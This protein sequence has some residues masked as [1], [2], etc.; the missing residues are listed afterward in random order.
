MKKPKLRE[1]GE[2]VKALIKGPYTTKFPKVPSPAAPAFRGKV[3]FVDKDCVGCLACV[4]VCPAKALEGIDDVK[5]K[6]RSVVHHPDICIFCGQCNANCL[7]GKGI[8]LTNEYDMAFLSDRD[9]QFIKVEKNLVLCECCGEV[10]TTVE[11]LLFLA[12]KLGPLAYSNINFII[13]GQKELGLVEIQDKKEDTIHKRA[14]V[15]KV[16]CPQCR[17]ETVIKE[18]WGD[19]R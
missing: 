3:E 15:M 16:L 2:A 6:K 13:T 14:N 18:E 9:K 5:K 7:T 12:K 17:R 11:H 1:L 10:I 19:K 8:I 4:E